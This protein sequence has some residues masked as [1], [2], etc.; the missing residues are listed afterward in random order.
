M[1]LQQIGED[2]ASLCRE[3]RFT[4]AIDRHYAADVVS[5]EAQ[6]DPRGVK[7]LD[8]VKAKGDWFDETFETLSV[9]VEGPWVNEP[10]FILKFTVQVRER[11]TGAEQTMDELA[12]YEVRDGK[13]VSDR[14]F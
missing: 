3:Q 2:I 9:A 7:G 8:A 13:V 10:F 11:K 4:V 12:L 6:G 5:T 14:F 1:S